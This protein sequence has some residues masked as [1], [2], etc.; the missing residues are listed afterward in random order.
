MLGS[1]G[2]TRAILWYVIPG[3]GCV[4]SREVGYVSTTILDLPK[5]A[6]DFVFGSK[7]ISQLKDGCFRNRK[8]NIPSMGVRAFFITEV[9]QHRVNGCI[10]Y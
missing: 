10:A 2:G 8:R 7:S 9:A 1:C 4:L 6:V 5:K 3:I